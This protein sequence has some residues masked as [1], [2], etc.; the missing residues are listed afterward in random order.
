[1]HIYSQVIQFIIY[2]GQHDNVS[3]SKSSHKLTIHKFPSYFCSQLSFFDKFR[4]FIAL[5]TIT[6]FKNHTNTNVQKEKYANISINN[7]MKKLE[8]LILLMK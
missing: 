2:N 7:G 1:M 6:Y 5:N 3:K 4:Y 8:K